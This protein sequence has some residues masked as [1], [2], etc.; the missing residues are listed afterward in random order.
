MRRSAPRAVLL[1]TLVTPP[2]LLAGLGLAHPM[3]LTPGSAHAW[4][5]LHVLLLPI[6]PLLG[7][8]PWLVTRRY[9][10]VLGAVAALLGYVY[11]AFYTALD[12]LAGIGAGSLEQAGDPAGRLVLFAQADSLVRYGVWA[13]LA[14]TILTVAVV[15]R[16]VGVAALPGAILTLGGAWSFF[17]SHIFWPRGVLTMLALAAGWAALALAS[18]ANEPGG[19]DPAR[20]SRRT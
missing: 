11:A 13:Y 12:V 4:R 14:A 5:D 2:L 15:L 16:H 20:R 3:H 6:F 10:A 9:S 8:A 7:L 18:A 17:D 1:L 19:P